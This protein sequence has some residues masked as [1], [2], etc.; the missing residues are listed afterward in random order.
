MQVV[1]PAQ[2]LI[3]VSDLT[4]NE[5]FTATMKAARKTD[6]IIK[7]SDRESGFIYATKGNNPLLTNEKQTS[8]S[9][10]VSEEGDQI[11]VDIR[12]ILTGQLAAWG[13]T[14]NL[15]EQFVDH[16]MAEVPEAK[17][18]VDGYLYP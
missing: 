6:L 5:V 11:V 2:A 8:V 14:S 18:T 3:P 7:D 9:I 4:R 1:T 15:V 17:V 12:A 16:L 13:T 10:S